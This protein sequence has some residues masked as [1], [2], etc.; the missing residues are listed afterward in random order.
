VLGT[1]GTAAVFIIPLMALAIIPV[2]ALITNYF[3]GRIKAASKR[4]RST[5]GE[6]ASAA[7]E[8]LASIRVVQVYG[9]GDYEQSMFSGQSE[10]AMNAALEAARYQARF[11]WVM[12]VLAAVVTAVIIWI[13]VGIIR[14]N[15]GSISPGLLAVFIVWADQM[16]KPTKKLIS[17]WNAFGKLSASLER[18]SD[19]IDL[20]PEVRDK[21]DAIP[22]PPFR[23]RI[24]FRNVVFSYPS[25]GPSKKKGDAKVRPTLNGLSFTIYPGQVVAVVGHT[26]AGKSTIAQ[27]IPRLYDP[28]EGQVLIDGRDIRDYTLESLRAQMSMVLQESILFTGSIVENIAYGRPDATGL[29]II[30]AA[31]NANADE[32]I[33]KFPEGYYT[34][35]GERGSN[36]SGGQRQRLAIAR[37]FI[38]DTPILILD[39]PSTGLDA[40]STDL[41]LQALRKLMK[42]K[43]TIIISHELNL[44]RNADNIIVIKEGQIEQMGTHDELLRA[45]GLYANLYI[46]QSGQRALDGNVVPVSEMGDPKVGKE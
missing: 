13:G 9:Q 37:A 21:P 38:R 46:M 30:E 14:A 11:S 10:K 7:Q 35:L 1:T 5:E 44:I 28:N 32:F 15:P 12:S 18:I 3:T 19:L 8:M 34:I 42:D 2:M 39:E 16:F 26:G 4:L 31:K 25:I 43:T 23:G 33:S 45:G 41:V 40:E 6:L 20:T 36:L 29:E 24:E 27:L 17:Q 22:A